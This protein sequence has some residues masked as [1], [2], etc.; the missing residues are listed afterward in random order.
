MFLPNQVFTTTFPVQNWWEHYFSTH[1]L[2]HTQVKMTFLA[3]IIMASISVGF[4]S[5]A[6][7]QH[8]LK[9]EF[10]ENPQNVVSGACPNLENIGNTAQWVTTELHLHWNLHWN[11]MEIPNKFDRNFTEMPMKL[12]WNPME[13]PSKFDRNSLEIPMKLHWNR[14]ENL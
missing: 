3:L 10:T 6:I 13:I 8:R 1:V 7:C 2:P 5:S 11:P 12:Y 14:M 9:R 4:V